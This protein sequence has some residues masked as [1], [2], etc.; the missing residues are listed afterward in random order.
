M[1]VI[2]FAPIAAE[3]VDPYRTARLRA[4]KEDGYA[5][6]ETYENMRSWPRERWEER[7][8]DNARHE[9][10]TTHLAWSD[11]DVVGMATGIH[12]DPDAPPELVSMW[13]AAEARGH[14]IGAELVDR[15][16]RW[17]GAVSSQPL[18]LWVMSENTTALAFYEGCGF[19][20]KTDHRAD[21]DDPCRN[22]VRMQR[23]AG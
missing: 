8:A 9:T 4:L 10:T 19:Q 11:G 2:R 15:I 3:D 18:E 12:L 1:T 16:S 14:G 22:E 6:T 21:P 13:V 23:S 5:F 20:V 17:A 7:V